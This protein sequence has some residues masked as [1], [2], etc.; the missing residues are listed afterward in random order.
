MIE[1]VRNMIVVIRRVGLLLSKIIEILERFK[2]TILRVQRG[3]MN[4]AL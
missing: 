2:S 4:V 3:M 1:E